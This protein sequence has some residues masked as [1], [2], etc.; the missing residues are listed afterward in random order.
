M[1]EKF[2]GYLFEQPVE[3]RGNIDTGVTYWVTADEDAV[4]LTGVTD[5]MVTPEP[6]PQWGGN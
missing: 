4:E 2:E 1:D 5:D 3:K 6:N